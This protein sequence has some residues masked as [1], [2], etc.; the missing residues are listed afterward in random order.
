MWQVQ[1]SISIPPHTPSEFDHGDV[2]HVSGRV[3]VA[4]TQAGTVEVL[5]GI[6]GTHLATIAGC[7]EA[8][9]VLVA[10]EANLVF[11][12]ARGTGKILVIDAEHLTVLREIAVDPRPNGLAWDATHQHLLVADVQ[13]NT[14]RLITVTGETLAVTTLPGRPRWCV[15]D[16]LR[17]QFL[18]NIREPACVQVLA[19]G[20]ATPVTRWEVDG[21]GPHGLDLDSSHN[22]AFVACDGGQFVTLDLAT[23]QETGRTTVAGPP[24]AIWSNPHLREVYVASDQP[25]MLTV[26]DVA[27][28]QIRQTLPTEAGTHTTAFDPGRQVLYVFLPTSCRADVLVNEES[29]PKET[30][31]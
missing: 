3:F 20:T 29:I 10:Q 28:M 25:G 30:V 21:V 7:T 31:S 12:A 18:V 4:H 2:H 5:D 16:A 24:D 6:Q 26:V 27:A 1:R 22:Q 23:G 11:A 15:F 9:G 8:S 13:T 17:K 14:A 19:A